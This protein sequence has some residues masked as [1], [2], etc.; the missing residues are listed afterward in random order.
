MVIYKLFEPKWKD[1]KDGS[2]VTLSD[3]SPLAT[4]D[5]EYTPRHSD[6]GDRFDPFIRNSN[7]ESNAGRLPAQSRRN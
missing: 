1:E 3:T 2:Y 4:L 5:R 6:T 7:L